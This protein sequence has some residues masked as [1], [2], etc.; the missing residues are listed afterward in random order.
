[1]T[2][3]HVDVEALVAALDAQRKEK[4]LSWR[5]LALQAGVQPSTLTRMNQGKKP[6]VNTFTKLV[7][8]LGMS[9]EDFI[10]K[11]T[12][13]TKSSPEAMAIASILLRGKKKMSHEALKALDELVQAA[14]KLTK[15]LG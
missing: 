8:W 4:A 14:K 10:V 1:M 7:T 9:T 5:K 3:A 2:E 12:S 13:G 15:E 6:D 11:G